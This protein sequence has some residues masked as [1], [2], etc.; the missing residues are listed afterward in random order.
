MASPAFLS[1]GLQN[2]HEAHNLAK[3]QRVLGAD[4]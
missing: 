1:N 4:L 3:E 2:K